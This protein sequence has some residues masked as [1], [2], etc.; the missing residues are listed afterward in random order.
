M[1]S[2]DW[3]VTCQNGL[4]RQV[5]SFSF[6]ARFAGAFAREAKKRQAKSTVRNAWQ[7]ILVVLNLGSTG[8]Q[9]HLAEGK[10]VSTRDSY[11]SINCLGAFSRGASCPMICISVRERFIVETACW[12]HRRDIVRQLNTNAAAP[13]CIIM[14]LAEARGRSRKLFSSADW[15]AICQ[16]IAKPDLLSL[17]ASIQLFVGPTPW[18]PTPLRH[19]YRT[20]LD[21]CTKPLRVFSHGRTDA[22]PCKPRRCLARFSNRREYFT[23][24]VKLIEDAI[25]LFRFSL[26]F[27]VDA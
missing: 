2:A 4:A 9:L 25:L 8:S 12:R 26:I 7:V 21:D 20:S 27:R 11:Q 13:L 18:K 1:P 6:S 16:V 17:A 19:G 22:R 23:K 10:T 15:L 24:A 5:V 3:L 14:H